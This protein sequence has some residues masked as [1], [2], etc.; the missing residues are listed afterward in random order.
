MSSALRAANGLYV[1]PCGDGLAATGSSQDDPAA[2][3]VIAPISGGAVSL[4]QDGFYW[5]AQ[6]NGALE[7]NRLAVGPWERFLRLP[8]ERTGSVAFQSAQ[9]AGVVS[10]RLDRPGT[11][12]TCPVGAEVHDWESFDLA[13]A[14]S[15]LRP[16][17]I[18]GRFF[19][20]DLGQRWQWRGCDGFDLLAKYLRGEDIAPILQQRADFG[21]NVLRIFRFAAPPNAFALRPADY[22]DYFSQ[23]RP[24]M[25]MLASYGLRAELTAGDAQIIMPNQADQRYHLDNVCAALMG[26]ANLL[27]ET[28]NEPGSGGGKNGIDVVK[29]RPPATTL[30]A[31]GM[32]DDDVLRAHP[33]VILDYHTYHGTR[34]DDGVLPKWIWDSCWELYNGVNGISPINKPVVHDE[35]MGCADVNVSGRRSNNSRFFYLLGTTANYD[36]GITLH[37][38]NGMRSQLFSDIQGLCASEFIRGMRTAL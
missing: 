5:S 23:L 10:A 2:Q 6:R 33:D 16:L 34:I 12:L 17:H 15:E 21:F 29:V 14:A 22:P 37:C 13:G 30:R 27:L 24:F 9:F 11:P 7:C 20:D 3:I 35:P 31:S 18:E 32:Y 25:D 26:Q 1:V 4:Q 38:D 28:C 36:L 19:K 8:G